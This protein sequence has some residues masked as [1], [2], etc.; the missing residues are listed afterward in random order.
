[1]GKLHKYTSTL[2][3]ILL[4]CGNI[5]GGEIIT[6]KQNNIKVCKLNDSNITPA[7]TLVGLLEHFR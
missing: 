2:Q 7:S 1:M 6:R 4:Y 5:R 3:Y